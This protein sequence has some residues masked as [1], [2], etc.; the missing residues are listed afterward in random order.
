MFV[1]E[2][3]VL[4]CMTTP[5][6]LF[7]YPESKR[8]RVSDTGPDYQKTEEEKGSFKRMSGEG[9]NEWKT[10]FTVVLDRLE[11]LPGM[12][13]LT[14]LIHPP[15]T[16]AE[17]E[18]DEVLKKSRTPSS[19]S[20]NLFNRPPKSNVIVD[21]LRLIELSDRTSAVM[22]SSAADQLIH[23]DPL[24][25]IFKTFGDLNDLSISSSLSVV[26]F[27]DLASRVADRAR[28]SASQLVLVPWLPPSVSIVGSPD[29]PTTPA[30]HT[31]AFTN[32]FDML[33]RTQ[34]VDK[35]AS[36]VHSQFIRSV[37][38]QC[39]TDVA[40]YVDRTLSVGF[41]ARH[42]YGTKQHILLPFFGGPDDRLALEFVVQLCAN[43]KVTATVVRVTKEETEYGG[44]ALVRPGDA[45]TTGQDENDAAANIRANGLTVGS[46]R[47]ILPSSQNASSDPLFADDRPPRYCLWPLH[48]PNTPP[49]RN[50]RQHHLGPLL[51]S[52]RGREP[53]RKNDRST[54]ARALQGAR[55]AHAA[56]RGH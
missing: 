52:L 2:A 37:F 50:R 19:D 13:A 29:A 55:V 42:R 7:L 24:L 46:V 33:F 25:N 11:H 23:T 48:D 30:A 39:H 17:K 27:G 9:D 20:S 49:V 6:V 32:P 34:S 10:R 56:A 8:T 16:E 45:H 14:Q 36:V 12:M 1:F 15:P 26:T 28:V 54:H 41:D 38:S 51:R 18:T 31:S 44:E 22:K 35:S 21:A 53:P 5:A 3:V 43:P 47:Y 40:L 4:T